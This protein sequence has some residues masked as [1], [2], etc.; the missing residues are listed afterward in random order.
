MEV[1]PVLD[2]STRDSKMI[3]GR[4]L[5]KLGLCMVYVLFAYAHLVALTQDG[6]RLSLALLVVFESIMV[7]LV[8]FRRDST[9]VDMTAMAVLAGL[10]GSF[11]ALGFRPAGD[12]QDLLIG[13]AIQVVGVLFQLGASLSL[14]RSFGLVPANR[15]IKTGGLYRIVRH[16]LYFSYLITEA[17]YIISNPS[18]RNVI[19][20]A[21]GVSF[22]VVRIHYEERLLSRDT[23]YARY[24]AT[25]RWHLVPG[26]W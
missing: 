18:W 19:I 1:S 9:D 20:L 6:F 2:T 5:S 16:P 10:I 8:F 15:G 26:L 22:Q 12:N 25:V 4:V 13:Q 14:G 11:A 24:A 7:G 17:G 3:P 21:I 23:Q